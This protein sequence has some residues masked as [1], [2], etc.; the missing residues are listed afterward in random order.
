MRHGIV[1]DMTRKTPWQPDPEEQAL[2]GALL[3]LRDALLRLHKVL[4]DS[5]RAVYEKEVGP[6]HSPNHFFQL[7]TNDSWFA[8][9]RP[10]SQ[11]IVAIDETMD[12]D[13]ALTT[14]S[15]DVLMS[16][17]VFLL[18]PAES[19]GEFGERYVAALQRDPRVVLAHAQVAKRIGSG[20]RPT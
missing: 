20:K 6:I 17:S 3:E 2:R 10:I 14:A 1:N 16:Q 19:G 4:L 9:L 15:V 12:G 8:W 11:L 5:E 7:L 13:E 18:I